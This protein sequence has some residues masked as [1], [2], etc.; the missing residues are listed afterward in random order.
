MYNRWHCSRL[1]IPS[2][3]AGR[4]PGDRGP[5]V[6]ILRLL[7]AEVECGDM[8]ELGF[9]TMDPSLAEPKRGH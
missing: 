6:N 5:A 2:A 7:E 3:L 8:Y 4:H 1:E 9:K